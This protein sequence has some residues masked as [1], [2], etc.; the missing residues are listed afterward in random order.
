VRSE[1]RNVGQKS[2]LLFSAGWGKNPSR[3]HRIFF[4]KKEKKGMKKGNH[5]V[6][7]EES[8]KRNKGGKESH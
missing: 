3:E 2:R 6:F 7:R 4:L 1:K 8:N 5:R